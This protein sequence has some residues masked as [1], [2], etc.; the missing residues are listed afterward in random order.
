MT[1]EEMAALLEAPEELAD[2]CEAVFR[3]HLAGNFDAESL[4]ETLRGEPYVHLQGVF[5]PSDLPET[6]QRWVPIP[7][8]ASTVLARLAVILIN[9][10]SGFETVSYASEND[11]ALFV[12]L[13]TLEGRGALAE[14]SKGPMQ[15][16]TDAAS[17]PFRGELDPL[18]HRIAPSPDV[19]HLVGLRNLAEVPTNVISLQ[20]ALDQLDGDEK[21]YLEGP[22]LVFH[23][24]RSFRK[25]T[26]RA[27]G[28]EHVL[29]GGSVLW[30]GPDGSWVRYSHSNSSLVDPTDAAGQK[31]KDKFE[32]ACRHCMTQVVLAP[33]DIL[34]V[35]NRKALHGRSPVGDEIGGSSRWLIRG[36]GL[37]TASLPAEQRNG[38]DSP[39]HVLFP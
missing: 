11:G 23:S 35:N 28:E 17:F 29:D 7:C 4:A 33:G 34:I 16:H 2:R 12:N 26:E 22:N 14:K 1:I 21:Q 24:Q 19:V 27:L 6:P 31:T 8:V 13:V 20:C 15:G 10:I 36:Y 5:D 25:G 9:R 3:D 18:N 37:D 39:A 38:G 32:A 30:D